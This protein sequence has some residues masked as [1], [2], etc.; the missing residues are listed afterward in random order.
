MKMAVKHSNKFAHYFQ[1]ILTLYF[2]FSEELLFF[3][4]QHSIQKKKTKQN[5]TKILKTVLMPVRHFFVS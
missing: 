2:T 3:A 1:P 4:Y 5:K